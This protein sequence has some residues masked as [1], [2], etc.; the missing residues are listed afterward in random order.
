[1]RA[2]RVELTRL[3]WRRAILLLLVAAVVLPALLLAGT[4]WE[5]RPMSDAE[6][7]AVL[8]DRY[9]QREVT[10][11]ERSPDDY[12][13]LDP[14]SGISIADPAMCRE[15]VAGW[16]G[17]RSPLAV[18]QEQRGT[19]LA[20]STLVLLLV[21]LTGT[22]F[23]GHD[24]NT[25]SMSNQLLFEPRRV[26]VWLTKAAAV[27][28]VGL[29]LGTAVLAAYWTGLLA[30][31]DSRDLVVPDG[32]RGDG[33]EQVLRTGALAGATALAGYALTMLFRSTVATVGVVFGLAVASGALLG[34]IGQESGRWTPPL[35]VMATIQGEVTYY[36]DSA[37]PPECFSA[38]RGPDGGCDGTQ[39]ITAAEGSTYLGSLLALAVAGSLVSFR[40]RDVP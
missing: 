17:G 32:V 20:A 30:L 11:C 31:S 15:L 18:A 6:V 35:N 8:A 9:A 4:A 39:V 27:T 36:D 34:I 12:M 1:M 10:R 37:L 33:Y 38:T 26:R 40:R 23:V 5:T 19:L 3:R 7:E 24:W 28:L 13:D 21:L 2:L 25:G 22:T 29:V 16:Y 14:S